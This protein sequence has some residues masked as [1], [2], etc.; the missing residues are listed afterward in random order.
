MKNVTL[1]MK[2]LKLIFMHDLE[3]WGDDNVSGKLCNVG[4]IDSYGMRHFAKLRWRAKKIKIQ[5]RR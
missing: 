2:W 3:H 1:K 4:P 5:S